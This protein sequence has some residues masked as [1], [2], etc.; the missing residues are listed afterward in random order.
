MT[1]EEFNLSEKKKEINVIGEYFIP[2][3]IKEFIKRN[4]GCGIDIGGI[5]CGDNIGE[6][7]GF[8]NYYCER[9]QKLIKEAGEELLR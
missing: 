9:C 8:K 7:D 2:K 4:I 3:H 5:P 1:K 6:G